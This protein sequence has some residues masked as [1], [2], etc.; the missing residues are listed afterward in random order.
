M[1]RCARVATLWLVGFLCAGAVSA[2]TQPPPAGSDYPFYGEFAVGTTFGHKSGGVFG[3]EVGWRMTS[4]FDILVEGGHMGNVGSSD[5][6]ARAQTIANAVN[7]TFSAAY[8][9][10]YVDA[11][12]RYRILTPKPNVHPYVMVGIGMAQV[13]AETVLSIN[14]TAVPP[15]QAG[16]TFGSDLSGTTHKVMFVFGGGATW[17]FHERAFADFS[18]R[19]GRIMPDTSTIPDDTGINTQRLQVAIGVRF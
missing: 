4:D 18:Y 2:Q 14:G 19:Y 15:D 11:G 9:I 12:I 6:D 1:M 10:N 13:T 7:A 16:V 17:A 8:H 3:G 5:L